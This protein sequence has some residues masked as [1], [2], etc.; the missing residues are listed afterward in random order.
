MMHYSFL[1][2]LIEKINTF[3]VLAIMICPITSFAQWEKITTH[4]S[5]TFLPFHFVIN[6]H[7]YIGS[8]REHSSQDKTMTFYKYYPEDN[9]WS[10]KA[11]PPFVPKRSPFSF[12]IGEY[13]YVGAGGA[14]YGTVKYSDFWR[15][16]PSTDKWERMADFPG[17]NQ[18]E[19]VSFV[20]DGKAYIVGGDGGTKQILNC[21]EYDP[22]TDTWREMASVPSGFM[23]NYASGFSYDGFG[24][25]GIGGEYYGSTN[26]FWRF[27]PV[28]NSW[29]KLAD[30]P[31]PSGTRYQAV[32]GVNLVYGKGFV[33]LGRGEFKDF[34]LYDFVND[35]W[36]PA[37]AE[38]DF[39]ISLYGASTFSVNE[40]IYAGF[41]FREN[42]NFNQDIYRF[43][44]C[45]SYTPDLDRGLIAHYPFNSGSVH[46]F[47]GNGHH[48]TNVN[49]AVFV[50]D[51][52]GNSGCAIEFNNMPYSNDQFLTTTSTEF[53]DGLSEFSISCWYK[54]LG[55]RDPGDYEALVNRD[56]GLSCPDRFGQWSVGLYD[57]RGAVFGR[58]NS[59]WGSDACFVEDPT[60]KWH[61]VTATYNSVG[62]TIKLYA[63]GVLTEVA[64]GK[65]Q[66]DYWGNT[67]TSKDIGDLFIG[68]M[69]TGV[70]DEIYIHNREIS[71]CEV[72]ALYNLESSCVADTSYCGPNCFEMIWKTDNEGLTDNHKLF[73]PINSMSEKLDVYIYDEDEVFLKKINSQDAFEADF[74]EPGTYI[75]KINGESGFNRISFPIDELSDA[76]KLVEITQWGNVKWTSMKQA[77]AHCDNLV[78]SATDA[79]D[80]SQVTDMS[81]M[82]YGAENFN[83]PIGHW[84]VSNVTDMS[85]MFSG[86][87]AFNQSLDDWDV[88]NVTN[89]EGMFG[90]STLNGEAPGGKIGKEHR[91]VETFN[92]P[93]NNWD[94]SSVT[95]M[96]YMF[97]GTKA[98]NQPLGNWD[99][100]NVQNMNGILYKAESFD[101]S[102][103][104]WQLHSL[105][106]LT[107]SGSGMG[108]ENYSQTLIGWASQPDLSF[109]VNIEAEDIFFNQQAQAAREVLIT[110]GW[111]LND[112]GL[113]AEC[114]GVPTGVVNRSSEISLQLYPNPTDGRFSLVIEMNRARNVVLDIFNVYGQR[115]LSDKLNNV[116][117]T[118]VS[119]Y[120]LSKYGKGVYMIRFQTNDETIFKQIVIQ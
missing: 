14:P 12:S 17:I 65:V 36:S 32:A 22:A 47:S 61:H 42:D 10:E 15:Y 83:S 69:F 89:M 26:D 107:L 44:Y 41:G 19:A 16:T 20:I 3:I 104:D 49:G 58:E 101:Q 8:E 34:W 9:Y 74:D 116:S 70:I 112:A 4:P 35:S 29:K 48:L 33:G 13:G 68:K 97:A 87:T 119:H 56:L 85:W 91:A 43:S 120:D 40:Y 108:C 45:D 71:P 67:P 88:S 2:K 38:Y 55:E 106:V 31:S 53:L 93:L 60:D 117:G 51:R 11:T 84:D 37:P 94:V 77:F 52:F 1:R 92:Q 100:S 80:L 81:Y 57:C 96:A 95:N 114:M 5:F 54:P 39:P 103:G 24:Y 113:D 18:K 66:C 86:A 46:D 23:S 73:V 90:D 27:D 111:V 25:V 64:S 30:M 50:E 75:L 98:F 110:N 82:F 6:D 62:N 79:P 105:D 78:I 102:L 72:E 59:V 99:V 115:I 118:S 28:E 109:S 7:V 76:A 63:N 21:W